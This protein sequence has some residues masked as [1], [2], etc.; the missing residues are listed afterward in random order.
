[1]VYF[2]LN[3]GNGDIKVGYSETPDQRLGGLQV[4]NSRELESLG[5]IEGDRARETELHN[6]FREHHVRGDWFT[7]KI[8]N[9]VNKILG[10]PPRDPPSVAA[11]SRR[12]G[13]CLH[14][15]IGLSAK[16]RDGPPFIIDGL[17]WDNDAVLW[18]LAGEE[19][20][21][22]ELCTLLDPWPICCEYVMTE[23]DAFL[24]SKDEISKRWVK[25]KMKQHPKWEEAD[26]VQ[27]A[28][29]EQRRQ[30]PPRSECKNKTPV[31]KVDCP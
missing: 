15:L 18:I 1:M 24:G 4:A 2:F 23:W 20:H 17:A 12:R 14:G 7:N 10:L 21:V 6:E 5:C 27:A 30:L 31:G 26:F 19:K 16:W 28:C 29:E 25:E 9:E 11:E 8:I 22:A 3:T 13:N